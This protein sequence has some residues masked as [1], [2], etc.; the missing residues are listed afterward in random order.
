LSGGGWAAA[1]D[2]L[3]REYTGTMLVVA[4]ASVV[5]AV[6]V[7]WGSADTLVCDVSVDTAERIGDLVAG[8]SSQ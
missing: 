3:A 7:R 5:D 6:R 4:R 2:G 1:L 8:I